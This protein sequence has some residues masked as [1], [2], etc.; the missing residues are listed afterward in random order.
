MTDLKSLES[1]L[2]GEMNTRFESLDGKFARLFEVLDSNKTVSV[3]RR[4]NPHPPTPP[5]EVWIAAL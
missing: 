3:Q 1:K 4:S 5:P 2:V